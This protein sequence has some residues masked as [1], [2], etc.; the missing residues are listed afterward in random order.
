MFPNREREGAPLTKK[1]LWTR[2]AVVSHVQRSLGTKQWPL[3]MHV[4]TDSSGAITWEPAYHFPS[5]S[6]IRPATCQVLLQSAIGIIIFGFCMT[7]HCMRVTREEQWSGSLTP[8]WSCGFFFPPETYLGVGTCRGKTV[9]MHGNIVYQAQARVFHAKC[10]FVT[11][12]GRF[13]PVNNDGLLRF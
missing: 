9:S 8:L 6:Q 10:T 7:P 13:L 4:K 2:K 3:V 12:Q 1:V 5:S 11:S